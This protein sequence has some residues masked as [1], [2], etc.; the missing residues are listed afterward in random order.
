MDSLKNSTVSKK[1]DYSTFFKKQDP[2]RFKGDCVE[3]MEWKKRWISQVSS[4]SPP[5]DF[6]IDLLKRNLP[7]EGRKKL[8]GCDSLSTAWLL[9]DKM[10]GDQKLI[11]QKLKSKLRNLK[12]KSKE[13]H[14]I[15]IELA[16]EVEY[17]VKR[18]RLLGAT[19]VLSIDS[20]FLNSIYKNLQWS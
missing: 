14:E 7:E 4:H 17:L 5:D 3:Y 19:S 10:Y 11:I 8:Y 6:E 9:L 1:S 20:D 18:L 12:P 15:V 2:P 13:L 16:D